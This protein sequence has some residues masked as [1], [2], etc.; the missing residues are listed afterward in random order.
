MTGLARQFGKGALVHCE[1]GMLR[2][3]GFAVFGSVNGHAQAPIV[4]AAGER[5]VPPCWRLLE[6]SDRIPVGS[7][8]AHGDLDVPALPAGVRSSLR[9]G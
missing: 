7:G 3:I 4:I 9:L 8:T 6:Q 2:R 1:R 5:S